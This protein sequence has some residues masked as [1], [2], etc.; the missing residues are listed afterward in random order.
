MKLKL[1]FSYETL[2]QAN[3]KRVDL[4]LK[5]DKETLLAYY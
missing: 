2:V 5:I 4:D 3:V 1:G